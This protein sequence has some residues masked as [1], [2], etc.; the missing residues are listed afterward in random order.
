MRSFDLGDRTDGTQDAGV[1]D[2]A[3]EPA[4]ALDCGVDRSGHVVL[5]GDVAVHVVAASPNRPAS[6]RPGSSWMSTSTHRAPSS[7]NRS[8]IAA[9]IPLAAPVITAT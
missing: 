4:E 3:V 1:V 5:D 7:M 8:V 2:D 9:P 6:S